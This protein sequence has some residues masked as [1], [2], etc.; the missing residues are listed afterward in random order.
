MGNRDAGDFVKFDPQKWS[1]AHLR[2]HEMQ[3]ILEEIQAEE[4]AAYDISAD[5]IDE[6]L[7]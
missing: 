1:G 5:E 2:A 3:D 7:K 6:C 4:A